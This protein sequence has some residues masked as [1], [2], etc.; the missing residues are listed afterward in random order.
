MIPG[1]MDIEGFPA[2]PGDHDLVISPSSLNSWFLCNYRILYKDED[3]FDNRSNEPPAWGTGMHR[4]IADHIRGVDPPK[5]AGVTMERWIDEC[6]NHDIHPENIVDYADRAV[7]L[8]L[9]GEML[10]GF[11][12]WVKDYWEPH[13]SRM[14][15]LIL[16]ERVT[17][18]LGTLPN[19][20][21]VWVSGQADF[22]GKIGEG[23]ALGVDWKTAGRGWKRGKAESNVQHTVY[24]WL[25]EKLIEERVVSSTYVVYNRQKSE[26]TW[27]D[28]IILLTPAMRD[29]TLRSMWDMAVSIDAGTGVASPMT[30]GGFG[31]GRGW[32]CK[33]QYCGAWNGC[34]FKHM[35]DDD[36]AQLERPEEMRWTI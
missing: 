12:L 16:E 13:G 36:T 17:R 20:R 7:L 19:G 29:A 22:V 27:K 24:A 28:K 6:L 33:P 15:T 23:S 11:E 1:F 10:T 32:H 3:W 30:R 21:R 25:A 9:A 18:P 34:E 8:R 26:W 14:E 31:D 5:T 35:I 2:E 4:L